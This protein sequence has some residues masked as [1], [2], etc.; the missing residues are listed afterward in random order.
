MTKIGFGEPLT[1]WVSAQCDETLG[2][3]TIGTTVAALYSSPWRDVSRSQHLL[4]VDSL[5]RVSA[6]SGGSGQR[7]APF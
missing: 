5:S 1:G 6:P 2:I 7:T 4:N 3:W